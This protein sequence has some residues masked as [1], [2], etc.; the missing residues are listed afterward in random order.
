MM[1]VFHRVE[2]FKAELQAE[3]SAKS[4]D[5]NLV[6]VCVSRR[7]AGPEMDFMVVASYTCWMEVVQLRCTIGT[8]L[9]GM[10]EDQINLAKKA[11]EIVKDL[12]AWAKNRGLDVRHGA[13]YEH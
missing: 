11:D 9:Y 5:H 2:E 8:C 7:V 4:V 13:H 6:R 12:E 10:S 3:V 1:V